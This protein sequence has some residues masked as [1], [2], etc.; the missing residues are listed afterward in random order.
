MRRSEIPYVPVSQRSARREEKDTIVVVGQ[1]RQKRKRKAGK[2]ATSDQDGRIVY[3]T[4]DDAESNAKRRATKQRIRRSRSTSLPFRIS[5]MMIL[6]LGRE[7]ENE[8]RRKR[9]KK[10]NKKGVLNRSS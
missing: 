10:T 8:K 5:W 2:S 6:K 1:V 9:Q 4:V 3:K 7:E